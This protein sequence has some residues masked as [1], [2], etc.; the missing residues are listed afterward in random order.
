LSIQTFDSILFYLLAEF[1]RGFLCSF[2]DWSDEKLVLARSYRKGVIPLVGF[3]QWSL[4]GFEKLYEHN[5]ALCKC[6][7]NIYT[8]K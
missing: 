2:S 4:G 8:F 5:R 1:F 6:V 3:I 7:L